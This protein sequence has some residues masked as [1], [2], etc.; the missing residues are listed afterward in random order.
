MRRL[1][2]KKPAALITAERSELDLTCQAHVEAFI[3]T[4]QP[5]VIFIAAAKVGGIE[6]NRLYPANFL[7]EN[8]TIAT[9]ILNAAYRQGVEKLLYVGSSCI[10][11]K[12]TPQPMRESQ[13]LTGSLEP[14]NEAYAIAKL[15]AIKLC[16]A[17]STQYGCDFISAIPCNLYGPGDKYD[18]QNSHVIPAL[19]MKAHHAKQNG[20]PFITLW[21]RGQAHREFLYVEDCAKALIH[22]MQHYN[23]PEPVNIG[24]GQELTIDALARQIMQIVGY[25]GVLRYDKSK[26]DGTPRKRLDISHIRRLGWQAQTSLSSGLQQTYQAYLSSQAGKQENISE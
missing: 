12:I 14:T 7:Y 22:L 8:L 6:A 5:Q 20:D 26:P 16:A 17:Y 3:K 24:S 25:T 19:I 18:L 11:P 13:L 10:Y 15:A 4:H 1:S 2:Q 21:G 9:T 23:G